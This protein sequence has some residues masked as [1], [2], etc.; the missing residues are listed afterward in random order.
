MDSSDF[1]VGASVQAVFRVKKRTIIL[2]ASQ[3]TRTFACVA[4]ESQALTK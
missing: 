3:Y 2:N 4:R 1:Y